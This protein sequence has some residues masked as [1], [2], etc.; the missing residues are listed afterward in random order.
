MGINLKDELDRD[1]KSKLQKSTNERQAVDEVKLLL[2]G[3][4]QEDNRILA[5]LGS[6][7]TVMQLQNFTGGNIEWEN[8]E[9]EYGKVFT[10]DQIRQLAI[11]Y[12]L[13]FLNSN[14]FI[15]DM[16][17]E[18]TAKIK[19]FAKETNTG[20]DD[21]TLR[22]RFFVLTVPASFRLESVKAQRFEE[23]KERRRQA[24]LDPVLFYR[25][26]QN[27]YRLI[28]QWGKEF[29]IWRRFLGYRWQNRWN[30]RMTNFFLLLPIF[31][32]VTSIIAPTLIV[33]SPVIA[34]LLMFVGAWISAWAGNIY[35][36]KEG[37][38]LSEDRTVYNEDFFTPQNWNSTKKLVG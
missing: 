27:H 18:V 10:S 9:K 15:G 30:F 14:Y 19:E 26:D 16:D 1:K 21:H 37:G 29:T 38:T 5:N 11:D 34:T 35:V 20:L 31:A 8:L 13:R 23:W 6:N 24:K 4:D 32:A 25:I 12:R 36:I 33:T 3:D 2:A 7:S 22:T 17:K 28:H